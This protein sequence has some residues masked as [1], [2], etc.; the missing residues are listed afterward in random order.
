[1]L[2]LVNKIF[3][4]YKELDRGPC[5]N[6]SWCA[7][8]R[9]L[10]L[11]VHNNVYPPMFDTPWQCWVPNMCLGH[12][13]AMVV[14]KKWRSRALRVVARAVAAAAKSFCTPCH[15]VNKPCT[16]LGIGGLST[17]IRHGK[18][19]GPMVTTDEADC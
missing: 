4:F 18:D 1:M 10:D 11:R 3:Y 14:S 8:G 15:F 16:T 13:V 6:A 2:H 9:S 7:L 19:V 12:L 5:S 17:L